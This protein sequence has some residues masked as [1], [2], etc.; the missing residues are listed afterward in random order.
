[1]GDGELQHQLGV[2]RHDADSVHLQTSSL[3]SDPSMQS[4]SESHFHPL[5][6]HSLWSLHWNLVGGQ[7]GGA[8]ESEAS[9]NMPKVGTHGRICEA[10]SRSL[11][12]ITILV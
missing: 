5:G 6:I 3:S 8:A 11:L 7:V 12:H 1:M 4:S 2:A 10:E 9:H